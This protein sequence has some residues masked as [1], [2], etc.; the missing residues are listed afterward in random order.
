MP[1][2]SECRK[3][4]GRFSA[5]ALIPLTWAPQRASAFLPDL[6]GDLELAAVGPRWTQ[7]ALS[8]R[9]HPPLGAPGRLGDRAVM[10]RVAEATVRD[11][12]ERIGGAI[13]AGA[14]SHGGLARAS[15]G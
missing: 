12:V 13:V 2:K 8:G 4:P 5:G 6:E 10:H 3:R 1:R 11:L 15:T 14:V 9:Y 7:L